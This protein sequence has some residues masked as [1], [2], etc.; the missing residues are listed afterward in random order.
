MLLLLLSWVVESTA[1][2]HSCSFCCF[3][4]C[5]FLLL[6][7]LLIM[8]YFNCCQL[9]ASSVKVLLKFLL[10]VVA[11][12]RFKISVSGPV[13]DM[14]LSMSVYKY[15]TASIKESKSNLRLLYPDRYLWPQDRSTR[16]YSHS[17]VIDERSGVRTP[18][19]ANAQCRERTPTTQHGTT[20]THLPA[21]NQ[22]PFGLDFSVPHHHVV[23]V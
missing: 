15:I 17:G 8:M 12:Q 23:R 20:G 19:R 18:Y 3:A 10:L 22:N 7:G 5:C 2:S 14:K 21:P 1:A 11:V 6:T 4:S 16:T 13:Q 9:H